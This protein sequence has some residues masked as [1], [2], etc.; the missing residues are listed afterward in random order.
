L[1]LEYRDIEM[2]ELE[3]RNFLRSSFKGGQNREYS[4]A[5]FKG[6]W[7]FLKLPTKGNPNY[8]GLLGDSLGHAGCLNH[9]LQTS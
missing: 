4:S 9:E 5:I 7:S 1:R 8:S 6:F 3:D 2:L